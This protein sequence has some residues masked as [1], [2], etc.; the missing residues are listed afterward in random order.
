MLSEM[1]ASRILGFAGGNKG[2][3]KRHKIWGLKYSG[4][5]ATLLCAKS[6]CIAACAS[7]LLFKPA[8][9]Q[10]KE[11]KLTRFV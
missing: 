7:C 5:N 2:Q 9:L 3:Y 10:R 1:V 8:Q 11:Q 6:V 4:Q